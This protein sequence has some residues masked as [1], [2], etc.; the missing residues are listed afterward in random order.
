MDRVYTEIRDGMVIA[1]SQRRYYQRQIPEGGIGFTE[2]QELMFRMNVQ[3]LWLVTELSQQHGDAAG[4]LVSQLV[5]L[6]DPD[7]VDALIRGNCLS[8]AP[9]QDEICAICLDIVADSQY[10]AKTNGCRFPHRFHT[11]CIVQWVRES[12]TCPVC[13]Q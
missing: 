13:R 7:E 12:E 2:L 11:A 10:W 6:G 3:G 4:P 9:P 8:V 5:G 1:V